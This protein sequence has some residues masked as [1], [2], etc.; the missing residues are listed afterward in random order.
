ML[1]KTTKIS[2][3]NRDNGRVVYTV[4][5]ENGAK[6][7]RV[8]A[9]GQTLDIAFGEL[10]TLYWSTGGKIML[11]EILRI[12]DQVAIKELIGEVEPEYNYSA[13]DVKRLLLEGSLDELKDCLDFAPSGVVDLVR[14][15]AVKLELDSE[16]KRKAITEATG[17][18]VT[19]A[20]V[21][22]REVREAEKEAG[23]ETTAKKAGE[24]RVQPVETKV[25][26]TGRRTAPPKYTPIGK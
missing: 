17:F 10:Q 21:A 20:I 5:A 23:F 8:F 24:R 15:L 3:T 4:Q 7:K 1:D 26:S 11:E 2:V 12:N 25:E 13:A 18:D 19:R 14:E 9:A 6:I 22:N 16:S